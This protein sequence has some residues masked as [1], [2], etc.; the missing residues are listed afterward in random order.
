MKRL[1]KIKSIKCKLLSYIKIFGYLFVFLLST[2]Y[3]LLSTSALRAQE[4][5]R[6]MTITPPTAEFSLNPGQTTE[7]QMKITNDSPNPITFNVGVQDYIVVDTL[8]TP[9]ILAPNTLNSKYSAASWIGVTPS[10]FTVKPGQK[11]VID[12]FLQVP[13][14]AKPGGHYAAA[15]YTAETKG[16]AQTGS[17]VTAQIGTLFYIT[18]KGPISET[19]TVSKFFANPFQEYGP[20]KILTQ[21]KNNGDLH[22]SPK[23]TIQISGLFFNKSEDLPTHNIFPETARDFENTVGKTL[24]L[25][26][27]KAVLLASYGVNNNLPLTAT[28]YFW[29]FPW[30][31]ALIIILLLIAI[32]LGGKYYRKRKRETQKPTD[33][34]TEITQTEGTQEETKTP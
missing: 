22:I 2:F 19:A 25:G 16:E 17:A 34:K 18:V 21:I 6:T 20:V 7:G 4:T 10:K 15:I 11:Q 5:I 12:Y 23:G 3:F 14:N 13:K 26:R 28:L 29:V 33:K 32:I 30:R 31:I 9:N 24:M 8:G 27:Y 1:P